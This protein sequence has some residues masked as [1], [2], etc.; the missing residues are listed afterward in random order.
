MT[1]ETKGRAARLKSLGNAVC[2]PQAYPVFRYI[3][4]IEA[5]RCRDFCVYEKAGDED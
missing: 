1:E 3:A 2:P 4:D 5:G